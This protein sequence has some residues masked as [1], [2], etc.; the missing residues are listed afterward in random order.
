M[1]RIRGLIHMIELDQK[2]IGI[3]TYKK[4]EF[5]Y[6]Y[7]SQMNTFKRY[8]YQDNFIDIVYDDEKLQKKGRFLAHP[9]SYINQISALG[10]NDIKI[11]YDKATV[12]KSLYSMLDSLD[13]LMFLDLEMTMPSY[14]YSGKG[15]VTEMI[16]AGFI[17][18][19]QNFNEI[20][21]Y[22]KY[23]KPKINTNLSN[24]TIEFL[25]VNIDDFNNNAI[26]YDE[27]YDEFNSI[28][29]KYHPAIVVYGRN[30]QLVLSNSYKINNKNSLES[31]CR[32]INLCQLLKN[33][34]E[35]KNDPGLFK[36]YNTYLSHED[37][38]VHDALDDSYATK[39]VFRIFKEDIKNKKYVDIIRNN[40]A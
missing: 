24:R 3:K 2:V 26:S 20:Y 10:K 23:I 30:D 21:R 8:L 19:D 12:S 35:L 36:V 33:F 22:D 9:I 27:F 39:E 40:M 18:C 11:Y 31:K 28:L 16:Q 1:K 34:Y 17:I 25:K 32:F 38:Q 7:N 37:N 6:F 15:Y 29:Y 14:Q 13:Y 4:I 5:F